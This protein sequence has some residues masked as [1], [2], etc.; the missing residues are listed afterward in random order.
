MVRFPQGREFF[1][2]KYHSEIKGAGEWRRGKVVSHLEPMV[3]PMYNNQLIEVNQAKVRKYYGE[4]HDL[5]L[6]PAPEEPLL[7]PEGNPD[8]PLLRQQPSRLASNFGSLLRVEFFICWK[9][10]LVHVM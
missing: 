3:A 1:G 5:P 7:R 8:I 10:S 4:W 6:P 9:S 2:V